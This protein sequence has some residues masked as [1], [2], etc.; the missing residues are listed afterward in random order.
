MHLM[1]V[2]NLDT[3]YLQNTPAIIK[4]LKLN[5]HENLALILRNGLILKVL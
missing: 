2:L 5:D 3:I 1:E 4:S